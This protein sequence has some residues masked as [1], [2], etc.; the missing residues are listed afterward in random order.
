MLYL[1][2]KKITALKSQPIT[3]LNSNP[4]QMMLLMKKGT[5]HSVS[6]PG[7]WRFPMGHT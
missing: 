6:A 4:M 7:G 2:L 5:S 3:A 1:T